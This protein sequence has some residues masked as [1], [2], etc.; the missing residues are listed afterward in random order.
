MW[1]EERR[2]RRMEKGGWIV[3]EDRGGRREEGMRKEE[4]WRKHEGGWRKEGRVGGRRKE[5]G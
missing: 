1:K 2:K 3:R 5:R 4:I